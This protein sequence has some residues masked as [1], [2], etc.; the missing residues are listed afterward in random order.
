MKKQKKSA[1]GL[2]YIHCQPEL[3]KTASWKTASQTQEIASI[4]F[5]NAIRM[6]PLSL[7]MQLKR[8]VG[9]LRQI[10]Q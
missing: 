4:H 3:S 7:K 10:E 2:S 5:R 8:K 6:P 9:S 1:L